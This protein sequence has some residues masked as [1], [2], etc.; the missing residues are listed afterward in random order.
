ML[1]NYQNDF[2]DDCFKLIVSNEDLFIVLEKNI[3]EVLKE[4]SPPGLVKIIQF[5]SR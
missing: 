1:E 2:H 4:R 5:P 3:V